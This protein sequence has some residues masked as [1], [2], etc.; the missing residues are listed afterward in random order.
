M[1]YAP[2]KIDWEK[3]IGANRMIDTEIVFADA[4]LVAALLCWEIVIYAAN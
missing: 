3:P 4:L 2:P 1:I